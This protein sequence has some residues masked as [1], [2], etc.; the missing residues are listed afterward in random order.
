[1]RQQ[2]HSKIKRSEECAAWPAVLHYQLLIKAE[3][4]LAWFGSVPAFTAVI[5]LLKHYDLF[6]QTKLEFS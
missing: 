6:P 5:S 2:L 4:F 3:G 1:M